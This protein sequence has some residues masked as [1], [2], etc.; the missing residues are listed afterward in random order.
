MKQSPPQFS[1]AHPPGIATSLSSSAPSGRGAGEPVRS[2]HG[3]GEPAHPAHPDGVAV[4]A[5]TLPAPRTSSVLRAIDPF[6]LVSEAALT[7]ALYVA[8]GLPRPWL[9][10]PLIIICLALA[11]T[12]RRRLTLSALDVAPQVFTAAG[13]G[14]V[15][16]VLLGELAA[17]GHRVDVVALAYS[18]AVAGS[19]A[20]A[21]RFAAYAFERHLRRRGR[22]TRRTIVV[23]ADNMGSALLLRMCHEREVGLTPVALVDEPLAQSVLPVPYPVHPI[24]ERLGD[25]IVAERIGAVVIAFPGVDESRLAR[26]A[27]EADQ[28][29]CDVFIVPRLK[30]AAVVS[31]KMDRIGAIPVRNINL[32]MRHNLMWHVKLL[33][34]R[35]AAAAVLVALAPLL[36]LLATA[37]K[38][39][40]PSAPVLF[41][42]T[43]VGRDGQQFELLKFRSM[44]P[45]SELDSQTTW[46]ISDDPRVGRVGKF[47]RA[48]SLDELP[49]LW[50]IVRGDMAVV[51]PRPERPHFVEKFSASIPGY[52]DRHRVPVGLTGW[53]AVNGLTGDTC[54]EERARFDNF[55]ITNWS[56]WFDVK[57]VIRTV[58]TL[59]KKCRGGRIASPSTDRALRLRPYRRSRRAA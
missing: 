29:G 34:E 19:A 13:A 23:G 11:G 56:L 52:R 48:T 12:Y 1:R 6:P 45:A 37:V 18:I 47:I 41:R 35:C 53:A 26:F 25:L 44:T 17:G 2:V 22:L 28:L 49:Q 43:R 50:N 24:G 15:I 3:T 32:P 7:T 33:G 42:Q 8:F 4:T 27:A 40:E 46:T 54:I 14:A 51:G 30:D 31:A 16:A 10:V 9:A 5:R 58:W 55:Y 20:L 38:L 57:I 39:S 21:A 36:A 59:V